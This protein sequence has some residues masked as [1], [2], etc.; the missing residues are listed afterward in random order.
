MTT[1]S[2]DD[3]DAI[4]TIVDVLKPFEAKDQERIIRWAREK[5]GLVTPPQAIAQ[6]G[7]AAVHSHQQAYV[8]AER[9]PPMDISDIHQ[10]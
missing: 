10:R 7:D 8:G 1:G 9:R 5:L 3:Y 2:G 4:R 6:H